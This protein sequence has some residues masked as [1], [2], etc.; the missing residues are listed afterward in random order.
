M[1][2]HLT[3]KYALDTPEVI[4]NISFTVKAG[5]KIGVVGRTGSGKST[6]AISLFRFME[7]AGGRIIIDGIDIT[8]IGLHDL[9]SKLTII[10]QDPILFRGTLRF[11]LDPF[12]EHEDFDLWEALRRSHLIPASTV[13]LDGTATPKVSSSP[14]AKS[15]AG[16]IKDDASASTE[17]VDPSKI[18]LDTVVKENGSN[19]SQ[20][21]RQLIALARALVR[22]SKIIVMDEATA[23]VDFETD[24][25]VQ[26]TIRE[27]MSEATII[28]I[29]HR[30][31]T[32]ADFDRVLVMDAGEIAEY[33]RPYTLMRKED[34]LFRSMCERSTELEALLEI[35]KAKEERDSAAVRS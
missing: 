30:I 2:D 25:K 12:N 26:T 1:V 21:Q 11:N 35:A 10:P 5:E 20:G 29:A 6:L 7:P 19:F 23:S 31:R 33:D 17:I 24:L 28:T 9:R 14:A 27:E 8:K 15:P 4:K 13:G 16:S 3:M 32:I 22:R 18:T 34:S